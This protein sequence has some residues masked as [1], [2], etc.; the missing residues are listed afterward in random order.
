MKTPNKNIPCSFCDGELE[1]G[2]VQHPYSWHGKIY[3]FENVPAQVCRQCGEKYFD[4]PVVGTM[5][6][7]VLKKAKPRRTVRVPVF[8]FGELAV[9][10]R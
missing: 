10:P 1:N 4:A 8:S 2:S 5:E 3:L 9:Q 6:R 7:A